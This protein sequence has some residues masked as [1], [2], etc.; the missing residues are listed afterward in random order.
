MAGVDRFT[1][2]KGC[3]AAFRAVVRR[4]VSLAIVVAID[5]AL[6][7][8]VAWLDHAWL[9]KVMLGR[10]LVVLA[11]LGLDA[12]VGMWAMLLV[13]S[14]F[15]ARR[16]SVG[17]TLTRLG[18][19]LTPALVVEA[20]NDTAFG[21]G[22]IFV[23]EPSGAEPWLLPVAASLLLVHFVVAVG[24]GCTIAF[25]PFI[26][27]A[28]PRD[29]GSAVRE[30]I[31]LTAPS[32]WGLGLFAFWVV[33]CG[34]VVSDLTPTATTPAQAALSQAIYSVYYMAGVVL[35]AGMGLALTRAAH[36][37]QLSLAA[38]FD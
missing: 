4:P 32:R 34:A 13:A 1:V 10:L 36:G 23:G 17:E 30:S 5:V 27:S 33:V 15:E 37:R 26:A 29:L 12:T 6:T 11:H 25:A 38:A 31:A 19:M 7:A 22:E 35:T 8:G 2:F 20:V 14:A 21:V 9:G 18:W 28:Q 16:L 24:V 3:L